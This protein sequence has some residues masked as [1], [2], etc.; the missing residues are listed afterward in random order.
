[1]AARS[2]ARLPGRCS[3]PDSTANPLLGIARH[4]KMTQH[5]KEPP[6]S[7]PRRSVVRDRRVWDSSAE[8]LCDPS[9]LTQRTA[10]V[11]HNRSA[12]IPQRDVRSLCEPTLTEGTVPRV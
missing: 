2:R 10:S 7:H 4:V 6:G 9:P 8:R 3:V 11:N 1:M 12:F 5:K